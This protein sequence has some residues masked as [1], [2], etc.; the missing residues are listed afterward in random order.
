MNVEI[1]QYRVYRMSA[2]IRCI[3]VDSMNLQG[4]DD[5]NDTIHS[6][7]AVALIHIELVNIANI[8]LEDKY[9]GSIMTFNISFESSLSPLSFEKYCISI[10]TNLDEMHRYL[11]ILI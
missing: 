1:Q 9:G 7:N 6:Q 5:S 11:H 3:S 4:F 8:Y 2:E 10:T